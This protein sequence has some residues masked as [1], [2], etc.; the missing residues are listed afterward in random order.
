MP[1]PLTLRRND[2]LRY[3]APPART[4]RLLWIDAEQRHGYVFDVAAT[5]AEVEPVALARLADDVRA[6]R[7]VVLADDPYLVV[8]Q[9]ELLPAKHLQLREQAWRIVE[10]LTR[11]EPAI[12]LARL[13]GQLIAEATALHGVSHP[14]IYRYLRRYWQRGQTP[15]ALLP[16]YANSGG[17]GKERA[18]SEGVKRGRPRK[19]GADPGLNTDLA[20][21]RVFRVATALYAAEHAKFSRRGAYRAML[22]DF[23]DGRRIDLDSGRV[24]PAGAAIAVLPSFGQFNYWLEQ[25]DDRPPQLRPRA[26]KADAGHPPLSVADA[27]ADGMA[28]PA[29]LAAAPGRPGASYYV[30]AVRA[31]LQL[32]SSTDRTVLA[33]RPLLYVV[34]D[35]FSGMV[36]GVYAS[37]EPAGWDG[38]MLALANCGADKQRYCAGLGRAIDAAEWPVWHLPETLLVQSAL[39]AGWND[40]TLLHNFN[41]RCRPV[42]DGPAD[43]KATLARRFKLLAPGEEG[44]ADRLDGVLDLRQFSRVVLEAVLHHNRSGGAARKDAPAPRALWDRACAIAAPA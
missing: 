23:F 31:E 9:P 27:D 36:A 32:V 34:S 11:R 25:D 12:F 22:R 3:A 38:A 30:E 24:L 17:R 29:D 39:S 16:D 14:T 43:W 2:L 42:A 7:A 10:G 28:P 13:R 4:V 20:L 26:G 33:G 41:V 5:S 44:G 37:L 40:D 21:R 19:A 6:G 15:N 1:A 18:A 35:C 8:A